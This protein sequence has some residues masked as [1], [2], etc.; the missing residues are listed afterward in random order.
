MTATPLQRALFALRD[1]RAEIESLRGAET[2]SIAIVGMGCR[3]PAAS[4]VQAFWNLLCEKRS[5][6]CEVPADRW[7]AGRFFH[8]DA[9]TP[10]KIAGRWGGF[11]EELDRF[12]PA[13]FG[14]S[15]REAPHVDPRQRVMLEV[16]WNALEDAGIPPL[17]LANSAT[18][19]YVATLSNDYDLMLSRNYGRFTASTGPGTANSII[20]NRLSYFLDLHGPSLTLDTACSGSLLAI[21]LACRSLRA[22]ETSLALAGGVSLNLLPKGD[23]FFSAAGALSPTG[24]C[25]SF[26]AAAD[27]IVRSEGAGMVI[28]KRMSDAIEDSDR[29]YAVIRGGAINH[30]GA[31]NGIMAPNGEAQK[32]V[33][34]EAYKNAGVPPAAAE[35]IEAH[36]TGTPLGDSI[37]IGAVAQAVGE[38]RSA[39]PLV[40]GSLKTNIGHTEAAAGVAG[41][42]KVALAMHHG[43]IPPNLHFEAWTPGVP[44]VGFP[45]EI[46]VATR[47][48]KRNGQPRIA[49]VSGFSFGGT[50]AHL[51]LEE[52][53]EAPASLAVEP[54]GPMLLL[55]MSAKSPE[56]L[57][58]LQDAYGRFLETGTEP[59]AL[60]DVCFTAGARRTHHQH[61]VAAIASTSAELA[62]RIRAERPAGRSISKLV[63]VFSGQGSH[64]KGMGDHLSD[65][66]PV[67]RD[68]L[69]VCDHLF[70]RSTG[71]SVI[72]KI[73]SG[74]R[75]DETD[76][77]QAAVFSMQ[78]A[79]A[80]LWQSFGIEP[81]AIVGQ[82]LGE[83]AAAY[84]AG[85]LSL[86]SAVAVV[87]H[88]SRLM[89]KLAGQGK[90]AVVGLAPES[91]RES[92]ADWKG[93]IFLAGHS[94]PQTCVVSGEPSAMTAWSAAVERQGVFVRTLAG[95]DVAFHTPHMEPLRG[96]LAASLEALDYAKARV[97]LMSTV[98]G[99]WVNGQSL[100]A[101]YWGRNLCEPFQLSGALDQLAEAGFD[102]FL[103]ISPQMMLTGPIREV[104]GRKNIDAFVLGSSQ[105]GETS[106]RT[107]LASL[108]E[109]YKAGRNPDW[110]AVFPD[111]GRCV[112]LPAYPFLR[113]RYWLDQLPGGEVTAE[114]G[115]ADPLLGRALECAL[116]G[117]QRVWEQHI[118]LQSPYYLSGHKILGS[119]VFPGAGYIEAA[120]TAMRQLRPEA[121]AFEI[122]G[123][124]FHEA[125]PLSE[126]GC[127]LQTVFSP[128]GDASYRFEFH[129][130]G[131]P[132]NDWTR[133]ASGQAIDIRLPAPYLP[134]S[135]LRSGFT[136]TV[137][138]SAHYEA[139]ALQ[140][141]EYGKHFRAITQVSRRTGQAMAEFILDDAAAAEARSYCIHPILIDA[142]LQTAAA[143]MEPSEGSIYR[144]EQYVPEGVGRVR[145]YANP[146]HRALCTAV[147]KSGKAKDP[148]LCFDLRLVGEDGRVAME[149]EDLRLAQVGYR[150]NG[151]PGRVRDWIY[152]LRWEEAVRESTVGATAGNWIVLGNPDGAGE[153]LAAVLWKR[154][155]HAEVLPGAELPNSDA[156]GIVYL[157]G[158]DGSADGMHKSCAFLLSLIKKIA[159]FENAP[160]LWIITRQMQAAGECA[161]ESSWAAQLWG[162]GRVVAL[163][164]PELWGGLVDLGS[165]DADDGERLTDELLAPGLDRQI[166]LRGGA[167]YVA[168]LRTSEDVRQLDPA[169]FRADASYLIT[170]GLGGLGLSVARWM[171]ERGARRLVLAGRTDLPPRRQWLSLPADHSAKNRVDAILDLERAGASVHAAAFDVTQ[172]G[173]VQAYIEDF[174]AQGWPP[175]RGVIHAAGIVE[176]Q[177][178]LRLDEGTFERVVRPKVAGAQA[179][180]E[181]TKNLD[182]DFFTLFSS[183]SSVLG[184]FGQA[185]YAAGN[186]YMDNLAQWRRA[187]GLPGTSINWGPWAEIGMF[188][189]LSDKNRNGRSGV[190]PMAPEQALQAMERIH[191][192]RPG[193]AIV[194]SAEWS[195]MPA[196]PL[197][198]ELLPASAARERTAE[199][200]KAS[201]ELLLELLL[202]EP[203]PRR[204]RL[205]SYLR[206]A[207]A[208]VLGLDAERLDVREQLTSLGM[209][210]I[211]VVELKTQIERTINLAVPMVDLFTG[212][213]DKLAEQL[214]RKLDDHGQ[215]EDLLA[216][217]E[218]MSAEELE[219]HLRET[220][221]SG[222]HQQAH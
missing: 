72:E 136:E 165:V 214:S 73:R 93:N 8:P 184:Q 31:S 40:L 77:S 185:H 163:E 112:S 9:R 177:L 130:R 123:L 170:G 180:H 217:V 159:T 101:G 49:G 174:H 202:A 42:I 158:L 41:V 166:A 213:V 23:V 78:V 28:L 17:S 100:D 81:D 14:I 210:S 89:K 133:H 147:L 156:S 67:F 108:A 60:R 90:T 12:D 203:E 115:G 205:Q 139:M 131:A 142:A 195:R 144:K 96:E 54:A 62:E 208:R 125:L 1:L 95:V 132:A 149:I 82:S 48:W 45:L 178:M 27:G 57:Q 167:R 188:A 33:L 118:A 189:R 127:Q 24:A 109:L 50:N 183:I 32:R 145:F 194:V 6:I 209:D 46:P 154:G 22:G 172:T 51:V 155:L 169:L 34:R 44:Q 68:T 21:E 143:T 181:A 204:Q 86:D 29:I 160:K 3:F 114:S 168:R 216:Q 220:G 113:D 199:E 38:G 94:S 138:G 107:M 171:T 212:T 207:A 61:R 182:L 106:E 200:E 211:M 215:V 191:L 179:L 59:A 97:D 221:A 218:N 219:Q 151:A 36:G 75:L 103:E 122:S 102:G 70:G 52:A 47:P 162:F 13:F 153:R 135:E 141:L 121:A 39:A 198:A 117:G 55:P 4:G 176:D 187:Q 20:A 76:V 201:S 7:D 10:G 190:F 152:E 99:T 64:W 193:Q 104:L 65:R 128:G 30:D 91:A 120:L 35:Y 98:T 18:G 80:A 173:E 192:R 129:A 58:S 43:A 92:I 196:S 63:F 197:F 186:A 74:E 37:E 25:H 88:R 150:Q 85:G 140:G 206:D 19:V 87:H 126:S 26:D 83:V 5:G 84:C 124:R 53:P 16:A 11:L 161:L 157:H 15:P 2:S 71:W 148:E 116:P 56:A 119:V 66:Y 111:G 79:L 175:I 105:R 146:G 69:Q 137:A 134:V 110:R 222:G 164:H